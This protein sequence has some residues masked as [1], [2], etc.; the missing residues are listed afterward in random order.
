VRLIQPL[1]VVLFLALVLV[2]F[3][4][5]RTRLT[6]RLI[7]GFLA[8]LGVTLICYPELSVGAAHWIGVGRGVDLVFYLA[9][10]GVG[11]ALLILYSRLRV[12][13]ERLTE[14]ARD[15]TLERAEKSAELGQESE[16]Y[17]MVNPKNKALAG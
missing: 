6:D 15:I 12:L 8:F 10:L 2:Y 5:F 7:V 17:P 3:K 14:M 9:H 13:Q 16:P 1:L 4:R 11:Y